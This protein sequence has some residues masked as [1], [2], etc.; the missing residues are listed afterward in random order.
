[1]A[2]CA[3][4]LISHMLRT[5][6]SAHSRVKVSSARTGAQLV[7]QQQM[8]HAAIAHCT[9]R[10]II[11]PTLVQNCRDMVCRH[12]PV[13]SACTRGVKGGGTHLS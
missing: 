10:T 6:N 3:S 7:Q 11:A 2:A 13:L 4:L 5:A 9:W 8:A 1:M 12:K